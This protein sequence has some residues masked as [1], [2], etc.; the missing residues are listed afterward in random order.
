MLYIKISLLVM[1]RTNQL[2]KTVSSR[3]LWLWR[4]FPMF[5][6]NPDDVVVVISARA[7]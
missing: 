1:R 5:E 4:S 6:H 3:L 7:L 2:V